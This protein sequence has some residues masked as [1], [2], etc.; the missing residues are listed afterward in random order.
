MYLAGIWEQFNEVISIGGQVTHMATQGED[1]SINAPIFDGLCD[2]DT[3]MVL[4]DFNCK[5]ALDA[6]TLI[7]SRT[8]KWRV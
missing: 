4:G 8:Y 3:T 7:V 6:S 2:G 1:Y 5:W